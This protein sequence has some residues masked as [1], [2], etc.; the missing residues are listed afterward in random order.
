MTDDIGDLAAE[1]EAAAERAHRDIE[2]GRLAAERIGLTWLL[3]SDDRE[4]LAGVEDDLRLL[5]RALIAR[6]TLGGAEE[7]LGGA[8]E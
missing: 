3:D 4:R 8:P 2:E 7:I 5:I 6:R 1:A